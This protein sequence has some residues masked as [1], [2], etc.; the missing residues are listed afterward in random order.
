MAVSL[1]LT[2]PSPVRIIVE[3]TPRR[4]GAASWN[5]KLIPTGEA[6]P[7]RHVR[8]QSRKEFSMERRNPPPSPRLRGRRT[9]HARQNRPTLSR[10]CPAHVSRLQEER[11]TCVCPN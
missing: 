7:H 8:R 1:R 9:N 10:R 11:G 5:K 4:G 2:A 6:K 3:A